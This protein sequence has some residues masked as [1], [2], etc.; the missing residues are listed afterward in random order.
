MR[1]I[2]NIINQINNLEEEIKKYSDE[3][4]KNKTLEF[5]QKL[6][7]GKTLEEILPEAY[8][9]VREAT[10]RVTKKRLYDEQLM[11]GYLLN[12][13]RIAQIKAGE[14][15]TLTESLPA[16]LNALEEK[17]VH[18][19]TTNE[20]LA[21]RDFEEVGKILEFLGISVG[22]I[23]QKMSKEQR[24]QAYQKDVTY[25]TNTEFGFDYLRDNIV[26]DKADIVQRKL[27]YAII[28]EVDSILIDEAQTPMLISKKKLNVIQEPYIK[29]NNFAKKLQG[30]RV[31][32]ENVKNK[33]QQEKIEEYDYV[34]D[35][36]YKTAELTQKGFFKAEEEYG[37]KNFYDSKNV[38]IINQV[39]QALRANSILKKDVDYIV[40]DGKVQ[41]IDKF[42]GRTM[43]GKRYTKGLHEAIEAK[44]NLQIQ[45][46]SELLASIS[47][48]NYFRMYKK[49]SGM[50]GTAKTQEKEFNDIYK[51]DVVE[52]P[53]HRK[54]KRTDRKD[55][56][57]V[58]EE[59]KY[60]AILEEIK[61]S[62]KIKQPVLV[63]TTS[64]EN[65]ERISKMLK[66]EKI[67]HNVLN[68]KNHEQEA[69]IVEEAGKLSKV[70]IA[71]N[72]A[73]RGT[74]IILGGSD[75]KERKQ[76]IKAGGLKVIG[77]EKHEARRIDEQLRGRSGRQ[78]EIGESI[79]YI[80]IQDEI[81]KIYS[82]LK[83]K[84]KYGKTK[85]IKKRKVKKEIEKAQRKA[86]NLNYTARKR[87]LFYDEVID[88][89]RKIIYADRLEI[90]NG[91]TEEI[92]KKFIT[93][94][95]NN[96]I[97]DNNKKAKEMVKELEKNEKIKITKEN[98]DVLINRIYERYKKKKEE[99]GKEEFEKIEKNN[100]ISIVDKYWI[101]YL[102]MMEELKENIEL[103][104]YGGHDPI[105]EY[106]LE[107]RKRFDELINSIKMNTISKLLFDTDY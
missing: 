92:I 105:Q 85:E 90:L 37:V 95:C 43:Y 33:K 97:I 56:I 86:E 77:T 19:V 36:T 94:F 80:S 31:R 100:L 3:Q 35:E 70:T 20:Y 47:T 84:V 38:V 63:G 78:G 15:K 101:D 83:E 76:V 30:I 29:A 75:K 39:K 106:N 6:K 1:T 2:K 67:E 61:K 48:Q 87:M 73:G 34:I 18:I 68:A 103:R 44:E 14:G 11:G 8:A 41:L 16:Y 52:V 17:G 40:E 99:I 88:R 72:M 23:I 74:N 10:L 5:K 89:Q 81:V 102:E 65:S 79:F 28:D 51:L 7:K 96:V 64:I 71:T 104:V 22:L 60:C 57:Y 66:K 12:Q 9:V 32:K 27:H 24:K 50:T 82:N 49:L 21:K 42:T 26:L 45:E 98:I 53:T 59:S 4:L 54:L 46:S 25:G 13:G 91:N 107:G 62:V 55:K 93:Y 69:K 58:D